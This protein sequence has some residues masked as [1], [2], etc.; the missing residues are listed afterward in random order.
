M[1]KDSPIPREERR[2]WVARGF[3]DPLKAFCAHRHGAAQRGIAFKF[4]PQ[5]WW[6]LWA[7]HWHRRGTSAG[8]LCMCRTRD[9]GAYESG[10]VRIDTTSSNHEER[11]QMYRERQLAAGRLPANQRRYNRGTADWLARSRTLRPYEEE[12]EELEEWLV[13]RTQRE[14]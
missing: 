9:E 14:M 11:G 10:N 13:G 8:Q 6:E 12:D 5:E 7:P 4:T 1:R 2:F 3:Q